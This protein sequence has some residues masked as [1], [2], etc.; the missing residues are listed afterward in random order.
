MLA[1][2]LGRAALLM[3]WIYRCALMLALPQ[4]TGRHRV[5][6]SRGCCGRLQ[7][8]TPDL[9]ARLLIPVSRRVPRPAAI[10]RSGAGV[11]GAMCLGPSRWGPLS[12]LVSGSQEPSTFIAVSFSRSL[13]LHC[14]SG[15][16]SE[17]TQLCCWGHLAFLFTVNHPVRYGYY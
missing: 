8:R 7:A 1:C 9:L 12:L 5:L 13:T 10:P 17:S 2:F 14:V 3:P 6:G 15:A 4:S 16:S 11:G